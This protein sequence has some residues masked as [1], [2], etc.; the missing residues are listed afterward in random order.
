LLLDSAIV[1][2]E[3]SETH[4]KHEPA[5]RPSYDSYYRYRQCWGGKRA[6]EN[7]R[8]DEKG[9]RREVEKEKEKE[10]KV[11]MKRKRKGHLGESIKADQ[12]LCYTV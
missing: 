8:K 9:R 2:K 7:S 10:K 11:E 12:M 5:T 6:K 3:A 1:A 4:E